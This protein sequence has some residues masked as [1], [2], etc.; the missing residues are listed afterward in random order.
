MSL[1]AR[2]EKFVHAYNRLGNAT[3]AAKEA[4]YS[5]RTAH[6]QGG[7]LLHKAE[8]ASAIARARK[9]AANGAGVTAQWVL[10]RLQVEATLSKEDGA[11]QS[12]RVKALELL[13]KAVGV[14]DTGDTDSDAI[15]A[16]IRKAK[17]EWQKEN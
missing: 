4:G 6:A 9:T 12:G 3:K 14:W 8:I 7:R 5:E 2:Q 1:T 11:T 13:G 10:E 16:E 17:H 15:L